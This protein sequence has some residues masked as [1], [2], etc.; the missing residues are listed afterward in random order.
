MMDGAVALP[1]ALRGFNGFQEIVSTCLNGVWQRFP[2]RQMG[3]NC[4]RKRAACAM[5]AGGF[6]PAGFKEKLIILGLKHVR[7]DIAANMPTFH[8]NGLSTRLEQSLRSAALAINGFNSLAG[9]DLRFRGIGRQ[10][11]GSRQQ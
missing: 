1:E 7:D 4:R 10:E 6:Y 2:K 5:R 3:R 9:K 8:E 11:E